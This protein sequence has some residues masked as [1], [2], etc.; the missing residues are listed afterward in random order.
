MLLVNST[1]D[2]NAIRD[3]TKYKKG[4]VV[5]C[6]ATKIALETLGRPI[7]NMPMLGAFLKVKPV[8]P[9]EAVVREVRAKFLKKIGEEKT[10]ANIKGI[11]RA[12]VEAKIG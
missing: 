5:T 11:Q 7:P 6:D 3:K 9:M 2:P 1:E 12:F 4:K 10:E 8:V